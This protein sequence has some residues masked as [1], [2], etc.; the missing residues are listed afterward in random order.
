MFRMKPVVLLVVLMA[1]VSLPVSS[2]LAQGGELPPVFCGDLSAEDC[3]IVEQAQVAMAGVSSSAVSIQF[4]MTFTGIEDAGDDFA[5]SILVDGAFAADPELLQSFGTSPS[6]EML[7]EMM[8]QGMAVV[9]DM[10][11]GVEG[12]AD[13]QLVLPA[14][15]VAEMGMPLDVLSTTLLMVDGV[16]YVNLEALSAMDEAE[17][18]DMQM[19]AWMGIDLAGMYEMMGEISMDEMGAEMEEFEALFAS[20]E[21]AALYD[22]EA[23]SDFM[24]ITRL[25]DTEVEGQAMA[26]FNMVLDYQAMFSSAAF[27]EAF[28]NYMNMIMEMQGV[29]GEEMPDNFMEVMT[30]MMSGMTIEFNEWIGLEDYYMHHMDMAFDFTTDSEA[31]AEIEPEAAAEMPEN[32]SMSMRMVMDASAFNEPVV[33]TAPEGAQVINPMMFMMDMMPEA[34]E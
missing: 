17:A 34:A 9:A 32:F 18:G 13:I 12:Q 26:V 21:L 29:D 2:A 7:S 27:Q 6:P 20:E 16:L 28:E 14:E 15:M 19:P 1:L 8:S 4:D 22:F 24:T 11:R 23:W 10:L 30:A 25:E 5:F 33:V 31:I 3:A